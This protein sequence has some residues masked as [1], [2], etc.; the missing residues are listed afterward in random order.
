MS[1]LIAPPYPVCRMEKTY[2]DVIQFIYPDCTHELSAI[3]S[4]KKVEE[5]RIHKDA[6]VNIL[7]DGDTVTL[8]KDLKFKG[9]SLIKGST[10]IKNIC[11]VDGD[12]DIDCK[13]DGQSILL[14]SE[15][16]KMKKA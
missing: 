13:I 16:T 14:K 4:T 7:K 12:H 3:T 9:S 15:I 1:K 2:P 6:H 10:K 8:T 11:R 5:T